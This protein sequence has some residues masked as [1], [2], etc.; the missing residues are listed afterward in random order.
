VRNLAKYGIVDTTFSR[1]DMGRIA[2][3]TIRKEDPDAE[4]VRYTVPGIKD[5]PLGATKLFD[6][7]CDGVITLGWVG[8]TML[9]KY[10][11][12]AA[13]IGLINAQLLVKKHIMDVTVHE[14]EADVSDLPELARDRTV[15]HSKN[16]V[17][18]VTGGG[19]SLQKFAGMGIRQGYKNAGQIREED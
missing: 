12:L 9:D 1:V 16:L 2:Y 8:K 15:K 4:I 7:G 5:L 13:S 18:L 3:E 17:G 14:D 10:S 11:Y 6:E 19:K